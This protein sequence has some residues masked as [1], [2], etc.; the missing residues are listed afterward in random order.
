MLQLLCVVLSSLEFAHVLSV[1]QVQASL[2][3]PVPELGQNTYADI[4][5]YTPPQ[6]KKLAGVYIDLHHKHA[7]VHRSF[8]ALVIKST[9][10]CKPMALGA[11]QL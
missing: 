7:L 11:E 10:L 2:K 6:I 5:G 8:Q 3:P 4:P 1:F 9:H